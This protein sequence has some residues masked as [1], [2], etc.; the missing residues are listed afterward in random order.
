MQQK[1]TQYSGNINIKYFLLECEKT[2]KEM[3][4]FNTKN[5]IEILNIMCTTVLYVHEL[6][7]LSSHPSGIGGHWQRATLTSSKK[8]AYDKKC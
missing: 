6:C 4:F 7:M 1:V 5:N 8:S 2:K 3:F